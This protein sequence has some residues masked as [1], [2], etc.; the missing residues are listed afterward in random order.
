M[1]E[2]TFNDVSKA[3]ARIKDRIIRT[4]LVTSDR[5][6]KIF[7]ARF[8]FKMEN[9]HK[10]GSFKARGAMNALLAYQEKHG[11]LP[12]K[13]VTSSS[14]NHAQALAWAAHELGIEALVYMAKGASALKV[15]STR[16]WGAE[17]ILC[18]ERSEANKLAHAKGEE[19]DYHFISSF[20]DDDVIAGQGTAC[21]EALE[22]IK[23]VDAVFAP[24]GGGGSVSGSL[25]A[26]DYLSDRHSFDPNFTRHESRPH[27]VGT[28]KAKVYACEPAL[29]NDAARSIK[30]NKIISFEKSPNTIADGARTLS[31]APRTLNYL[32]KV[33]GILEIAEEDIIFATQLLT[34]YLKYTIEPTS[35]MAFAGALQFLK[36][37]EQNNP[38]LLIIITGGNIACETYRVIYAQDKICEF[39]ASRDTVKS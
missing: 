20:D 38:K 36:S 2:L 7:G 1:K 6:D 19:K 18:E 17:V 14:G 32:K 5:L 24:C 10:T 31:I 22:E 4:P 12:K 30:E 16:S 26:V 33:D 34:H 23:S 21:L 3:Q 35:A 27:L 29:A 25:L 9:L 28:P 11:K 39:I 37:S 15:S 13:V 8:F